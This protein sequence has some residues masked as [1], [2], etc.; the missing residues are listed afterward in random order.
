MIYSEELLRFVRFA[1]VGVANT[2]VHLVAVVFLVEL[3]S[4]SAPLA[5]AMAFMIAN[6]GSYFLNS[7]WTFRRGRSLVGYGRFVLISSA[8]LVISWGFVLASQVLAQHYLVGVV[9][10]VIVVAVVG[11]LLNKRFVFNS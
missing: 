7:G 8:G 6:M 1:C 10:S 5:N 3:V 11:Y 9:S 4:I 2:L